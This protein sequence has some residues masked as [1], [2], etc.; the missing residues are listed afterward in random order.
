VPVIRVVK[1]AHAREHVPGAEI[2]LGTPTPGTEVPERVDAIEAAL[3]DWPMIEAVP[4]G[5]DVLLA[6]HDDALVEHLRTVWDRWGEYGI[7]RVT[8]YLFPTAGMLGDL[9]Q[10]EPAAVHGAA[11]RYGYDTMTLIGPGTWEAARGAVDVAL[12]CVDEVG[13]GVIYGLTRPPGHH[14]TRAAYGGSCYLNNAAVAAEALRRAG[15]ERVAIVDIDAHHGNGTQDV[16][17]A[18]GDVLY[19]SLHVDPG[20]GWFPH[21]AGFAEET[22]IG[23][24]TGA[25]LNIPLEP[26]TGDMRWLDAIMHIVQRVMD[27]GATAMVISLGVDA[28]A[29]DPES[30][31]EITRSG[32][33]RAGEL[34]GAL[35]IPTVALQEGGYHLPTL[36]PLVRATL[37]GL[38]R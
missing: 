35:A 29:D 34:L 8:P 37:Q 4:H 6:V 36:G 38:A 16:F 26:G 3:A 18:R 14:V 32:Y 30:P 15:H 1:S 12:T 2:W 21:Y 20:A 5:D 17:Y 28:A 11:G 9:P 24:G 19:A 23:A 31:L 33:F 27:F 10:R 22:G 7:D 25:N 13:N